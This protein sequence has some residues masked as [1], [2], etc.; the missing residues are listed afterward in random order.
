[1][2]ASDINFDTWRA[3]SGGR[4]GGR[5]VCAGRFGRCVIGLTAESGSG[6]RSGGD[7]VLCVSVRVGL[8]GN[9]N[10]WAGSLGDPRRLASLGD[11]HDWLACLGERLAFLARGKGYSFGWVAGRPGELDF[12]SGLGCPTPK[13]GDVTGPPIPLGV[14]LGTCTLAARLCPLIGTAFPLPCAV[15]SVAK[16]TIDSVRPCCGR[17]EPGVTELGPDTALPIFDVLSIR[18]W[19]RLCL[20]PGGL[21]SLRLLCLANVGLCSPEVC[22]CPGIARATDTGGFVDLSPPA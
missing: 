6:N 13:R 2:L 4:S 20:S 3:G 12:I 9:T 8:G 18:L 21:F 11:G 1:M 15:E 10:A 7:T 14:L 22:T 17:G 19:L 16:L 5:G